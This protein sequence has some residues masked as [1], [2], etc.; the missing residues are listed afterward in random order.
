MHLCSGGLHLL[1]PGKKGNC[2]TFSRVL[3]ILLPIK[4]CQFWLRQSY[5]NSL[6]FWTFP[7]VT[8]CFSF[9]LKTG[10]LKYNVAIVETVF[11]PHGLLLFVLSS[12]FFEQIL[13]ILCSLLCTGTGVS[14]WL[15][16]RSSHGWTDISLNTWDQEVSQPWTRV[17]VW[18]H[19]WQ[20]G[21]ASTLSQALYNG[22]SIYFLL[23]QSFKV[24]SGSSL[25][26]FQVFPEHEFSFQHNPYTLPQPFR[27][28]G[29]CQSICS[30]SFCC[31]SRVILVERPLY[32][33]S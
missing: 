27:F 3:E 19:V 26:V 8:A 20:I 29:L 18:G 11:P 10:H 9:L 23:L 28:P 4:C 6:P 21:Y 33:A 22:L 30:F 1:S 14:A 5:K 2:K 32:C 7:Y 16:Q 15:A 13:S 17:G 12:Y 31:P 25:E 24:A